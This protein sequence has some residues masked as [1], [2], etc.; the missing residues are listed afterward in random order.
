MVLLSVENETMAGGMILIPKRNGRNG[1]DEKNEIIIVP[2]P[3]RSVLEKLYNRA[4]NSRPF[5]ASEQQTGQH[6]GT[7]EPRA[8]GT[9]VGLCR[10]SIACPN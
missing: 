1:Y 6:R 3:S 10:I 4:D 8:V 9:S 2:T 7:N 5:D